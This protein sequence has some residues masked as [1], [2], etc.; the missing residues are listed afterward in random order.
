MQ[1][2]AGRQMQYLRWLVESRPFF[3]RIPDQSLVV[4]DSGVGGQHVQ[5][6]RDHDGSYAFVYLPAIDTDK[7]IDLSHLKGERIR[8]WWYDPRT[9]IGTLIDTFDGGKQ[10]HF[11]TPPYG[12]DWVLVLDDVAANYPPPG[13]VPWNK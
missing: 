3:S 6:A 2:P 11:R 1:R 9:G 10:V 5:A 12:P 7:T 13:L 8:A 4:G